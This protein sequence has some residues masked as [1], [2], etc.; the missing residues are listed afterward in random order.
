MAA[1]AVSADRVEHE[2]NESM[3]A[4]FTPQDHLANALRNYLLI[5]GL[6]EQA[7]VEWAYSM[8]DEDN[9]RPPA[10]LL[11]DRGWFNAGKYIGSPFR[12]IDQAAD[13]GDH[14][15]PE[16]QAKIAEAVTAW[17]LEHNGPTGQ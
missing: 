6:L 2:I 17:Y 5:D 4:I 15:G 7:G 16:S 1:N 13:D 9:A 3:H 11:M 12:K 14:P 10:E 8:I